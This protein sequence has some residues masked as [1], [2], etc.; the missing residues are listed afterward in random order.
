MA[1]RDLRDWIAL[2]ER[3]GEL[4]RVSAEVDP[5]LE[6]T[7]IV[8]RTVKAGGPALLFERPKGSSHPLLINQ[9]GTERRMCLGFGVDSLDDIGRRVA[10]VLEMQ[11]PDGLMEKVRGLQKL[12]SIADSRPQTVRKGAC[13]EVV[14]R[15]DEVDL[16]LLPIQRC[17]PGDPAPFITLPAVITRDPRDGRRNVGMYRMQVVDRSTTFMH[18]QI[19][20]DGRADWLATDGRIEVAV[21]IGLDPATAYSASAP[22]PK[23]IDEL[24]LAGFLR[25]EPVELVKGI[26]VDLEVPAAAEI[27]LEGYIEK[28]ELGVEGPFG[29]HTGFYTPA[30]PFPVFHLT[31]LTMRRDAIYPSIVV[32][33]PPQEDAW[34]GK[35][36]ERIFLP[37]VRATVP[38]IVDYDLPVAGAFHNCAIVSIRKQFPGHAHKVMHAIW[39]LGMLSL[40]KC[41]VIVDEHVDVHDYEQVV[42]YAGA[43]VDAKRDVVIAEG[44]LDHLDHAPERQFLGGKLGIDATAKWP[45][46]GAR[47]WPTEIEMSAEI[48]A[49]VDRR[50]AEYG[51]ELVPDARRDGFGLNPNRMREVTR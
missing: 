21:A 45:E 15:G 37:A 34:L 36:T 14:L 2:L 4:V 35:A 8:D 40:T 10:D 20:K 11:P 48:R 13:Q 31:A 28:D 30:E 6:I 25:G 12:K 42:F 32:G 49:L 19:H 43:N 9:F 39:G 33:K 27:V 3:E 26:T 47:P 46:E 29:D 50:W 5:D 18:W 38:E 23:H 16:G 1:I 22:L 17:W 44:P 41:V 24:M 51:I 7:E